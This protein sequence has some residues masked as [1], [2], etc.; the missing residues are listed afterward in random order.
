[1]RYYWGLDLLRFFSATFVVLFHISAFGG[2]VPSWPVYPEAA[3]LGLLAPVG[4]FGWI[5]VQLFFVLSGF[6]ISASAEN[7]N[8][9]VFLKKRAIRLFPALWL[10]AALALAVRAAWGEALPDLFPSFLRAIVLSPQGPYIDGVVWSL[11]IEAVF[12]V[13]VA[14]VIFIAPKF[15]GTSRCLTISAFGIGIASLAFTLLNWFVVKGGMFAGDSGLVTLL[16][17]FAFDVLLLRHGVFFALGMLLFQTVEQRWSRGKSIG[18]A[19]FG[20]ACCLQIQ[21][22]VPDDFSA[23]AP[24]LVWVIAIFAAYVSARNSHR[25]INPNVRRFMR[26]VGLLTYPLYLN[27]FVLGQAL[28]PIFLM[29][30]DNTFILFPALFTTLLSVSA[31]IS[32]YFEPR[33]QK[34]MRNILFRPTI[35]TKENRIA[36]AKAGPSRD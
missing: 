28:M 7:A 18:L 6:V 1:V 14:G 13:L 32:I 10:S 34:K 20:L 19:V 4:W 30:I 26:P 22:Q 5:G 17:R 21:T 3:P 16:N 11:V 27:H 8:A 24:I 36:V 9:S 23:S 29:H 25:M 15:G 31:I 35:P 2:D 33:L 12:Y